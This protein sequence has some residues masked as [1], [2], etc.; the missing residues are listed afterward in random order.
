MEVAIIGTVGVPAKYGGFETLVENL[1]NYKK[2]TDIHY[3]VYCSKRHYNQKPKFYKDAKLFYL[4]FR[5]NG[6]QSIIYDIISI[7]HSFFIA[8]SLLILGVSGC[9]ILPI[10]RLFSK[11]QVVVNIDG[12]E[13]RREKWG[14][15]TRKFLKFSEKM[16]V[17]Y[18]DIVIADNK[19]IQD[20]VLVEYGRIAK[21]IEYGGDNNILVNDTSTL[22]DIGLI[23]GSYSITVCRIEPENNVHVILEAF[24][25]MPQNNLVFV[26]NWEKTK[27]G[28]ALKDKYTD[29]L[30][31]YML[32][33]IYDVRKL[34]GLRSNACS[35]VHGHSAGGT[36]PSLVEAMNLGLPIIAFDVVYN[37]ETTENKASYFKDTDSLIQ[38]IQ[39]FSEQERNRNATEMK[40]IS[41]QRYKWSI[42][43]Q[44]YEDVFE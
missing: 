18:A 37:K 6:S 2:N 23:K 5:A 36:N 39:S 41:E 27:Y 16:A 19:G 35:Y 28:R 31:I 25:R 34:N 9:M 4:P 43:I 40:R 8:D 42:V 12:L 38:N 13:H 11:K 3:I 32:S 29:Y 44:K 26:G 14:K 30:N 10:I 7:I 17:K 20:Y 1:L 22:N 15:W 21:L 33:S 24:S